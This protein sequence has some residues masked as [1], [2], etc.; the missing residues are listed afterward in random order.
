ARW[1]L[2]HGADPSAR[3]C[4]GPD[5]LAGHTPL[6]HAVVTMGEQHAELVRLFV[7]HGVDAGLRATVRKQLRDMGD[8]EKEQL[9]VYEQVT[10]VEYAR[11]Y[12][13]PR[14]ANEVGV[15]VLSPASG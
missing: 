7:E 4:S 9:R 10:P 11:A 6:F 14:W 13:E 2:E 3:A 5:D 15:A 8:P 12:V 1:L